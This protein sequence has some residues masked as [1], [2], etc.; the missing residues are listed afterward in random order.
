[1]LAHET[2][3]TSIAQPDDD[4]APRAGSGRYLL[5]TAFPGGWLPGGT[6]SPRHEDA[7]CRAAGIRPLWSAGRASHRQHRRASPGSDGRVLTNL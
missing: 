6:G 3:G 1:M 7:S 5:S 2:I 4:T